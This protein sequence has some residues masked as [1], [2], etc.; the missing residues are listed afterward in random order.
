MVSKKREHWV[1]IIDPYQI[2]VKITGIKVE[3]TLI[4]KFPGNEPDHVWLET[5]DMDKFSTNTV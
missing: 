3:L 4:G 1:K 2:T 5:K